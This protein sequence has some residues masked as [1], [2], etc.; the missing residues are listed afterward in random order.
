LAD[1]A[2]LPEGILRV[3]DQKNRTAGTA[4]LTHQGLVVTCAHVVTNAGSGPD[5]SLDL[6]K[7]T[8]GERLRGVVRSD[9]WSPADAA[10]VAVVELAEPPADGWLSLGSSGWAGRGRFETYGFPTLL[11][12]E[13]MPGECSVLATPTTERGW[14][15]LALRSQ[16]ITHGFSGAPIWDAALGV[17]IGMVVSIAGQRTV[18]LGRGERLHEP[19][20]P[21]GRMTQSAFMIPVETI[22]SV[23]PSLELSRETP[24]QALEFFRAEHA[25]FYFGR[26]AATR[27][28][29]SSLARNGIVVLDRHIRQWEV[30]IAARGTGQGP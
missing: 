12:N 14:P 1:S 3:V 10:D 19:Q 15:R 13:G 28:V 29:V 16:E 20:D 22:R 11:A 9:A 24:Y 6:V 17:V 21:G 8:S 27:E 2:E 25:R 30:F 18:D 4:F 23:C 26:D 7:L 5:Q